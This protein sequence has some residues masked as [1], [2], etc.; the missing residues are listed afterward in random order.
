[1]TS[2]MD[3]LLGVVFS[4]GEMVIQDEENDQDD[5]NRIEIAGYVLIGIQAGSF[6]EGRQP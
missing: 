6:M 2:S 4:T 3:A 5:L 1:M